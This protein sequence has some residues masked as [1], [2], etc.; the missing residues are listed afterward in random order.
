PIVTAPLIGAWAPAGS[1]HDEVSTVQPAD[2]PGWAAV[3]PVDGPVATVVVLVGAA[4]TRGAVTRGVVVP[5]AP[6]PPQEIRTTAPVVSSANVLRLAAPPTIAPTVVGRPARETA[7]CQAV[8]VDPTETSVV[9]DGELGD[10]E[11]DDVDDVEVRPWWQ[12]KLNLAVIVVGLAILCG[13]LGWLIGNNRATPDPNAVDIGFL[14]DMRTHHEQAVTMGLYYLSRPDTDPNLR[15][16]AREVVFDQGIDIGRMIELLRLFGEH[17]T[18]ESDTAM[19]WMN[20]PTPADR[21][22][23]MATEA[24]LDK[25]LAASGKDADDQF[26]NL[27]IAHHEGGIH[28]AQYAAAHAN[29]PEVRNIANSTVSGQTGEISE[30]RSLIA[31]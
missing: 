18:N 15:V 1:A 25:L 2:R 12:S 24:D 4:E 14:Q 10:D 8:D 11:V 29:V 9:P 13:A 3:P 5:V 6:P 20:E 19:A 21:M 22:P 26:A 23:G 30:L 16:I 31:A 7:T 17:E 27:M 28:M